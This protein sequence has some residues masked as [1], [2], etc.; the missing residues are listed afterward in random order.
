[1]LPQVSYAVHHLGS[2]LHT[3]HGWRTSHDDVAMVAN[4]AEPEALDQPVLRLSDGA[5]AEVV[6]GGLELRDA[7]DRL[8]FRY[9]AGE[10]ELLAPRGDLTLDAP[11]GRVVL[12]SATDIELEA[13]R[14]LV[15]RAGRSVA[16]QVGARLEPQ[17][18]VDSQ[19][20][21]VR[22]AELTAKTEQA[23]L[24]TGQASVAARV[25]S[26][27]A[28]V[29]AQKVG[30]YELVATRIVERAHDLFQDITGLLQVRAGRARTV[31]REL[32]QMR[33]GRT[34]ITSEEDTTIDGKPV[35]LG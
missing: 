7:Q 16:V 32:Y 30:H 11:D 33:S 34:V 23:E 28:Q 15:H 12:R 14:D 2:A 18:C 19:S 31:V 21:Q 35:R 1:M 5:R 9:R 13:R 22:S 26:S 8:L 24:V 29:L 27:T 10:A 4:R 6:A 3:L 17:I 25:I 20:V